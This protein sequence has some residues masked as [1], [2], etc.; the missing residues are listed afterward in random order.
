MS[1]LLESL[2]FD[3]GF[4]TL[5]AGSNQE[6]LNSEGKFGIP[7]YGG[8]AA[9]LH[10]Y[11]YRVRMRMQRE[12]L[13]DK[14]EAK[15]N[16]PLGLRLVEGLRGQ[17]LRIAQSLD[18]KVLSA[19]DGPE[20]LLQL[21]EQVLKP[22]KA[23]EAR[24]LYAAGSRDGGLL[25]RQMSEPMSS[26]V[27]RRKAWW[28]A[29]RQLDSTMQVS[30]GILA[31]QML[32]NAGVSEDQRLM[33][34]TVL[35]NDLDVEKVSSELLNQH[36]RIHEREKHRGKGYGGS[37]G[38]QHHRQPWKKPFHKGHR[39]YHAEDDQDWDA[40]SQSL[41]GF[42]ADIEAEEDFDESYVALEDYDTPDVFLAEQVAMFL[43]D[44]LDF[45]NEEAC[46][47]A[48][49]SIQLDYEAFF[50]RNQA[51]GKGHGGFAGP[52]HFEVSGQLSMQEKKAR[53][54]QLK[55]RTECRKCGQK[56]H[57]SGDPRC[58]KSTGSKSD[59]KGKK[60]ATSSTTST[61]ASGKSFKKGGVPK[62]RVVYFAM[63]HDAGNGGEFVSN[64]AV[65]D[66]S[67][68]GTLP[69]TESSS[70]STAQMLLQQ[71]YTA[72]QVLEFLLNAPQERRSL[73][74]VHEFETL[75][76]N[77]QPRGVPQSF[78]PQSLGEEPDR[79]GCLELVTQALGTL[80]EMEIDE[81][82]VVGEATGAARDP[83]PVLSLA[84]PSSVSTNVTSAPETP[85]TP[86]QMACEHQNITRRGSNSYFLL[87]TCLQC[88]KVLKRERREGSTS[89]P[90]TTASS[91]GAAKTKGGNAECPHNRV[92]WRGSNGVKWR[93][94]CLDCG[95]ITQGSHSTT[96]SQTTPSAQFLAGAH[97]PDAEGDM[98]F[99]VRDLQELMRSSQMVAMMKAQ[100]CH[101]V[102]SLE[103]VHQIIDAVGVNLARTRE[104]LPGSLPTS[105]PATS[106]PTSP[107]RPATPA[108]AADP[109]HVAGQ[110]TVTF[111]KYK[112]TPYWN[113]WQDTQYVNW[114]LAEAND[115][116]CKGMK[117]LVAYFKQKK[118]AGS[119]HEGYMAAYEEETNPVETEAKEQWLLAVLD[120][121]CNR[122]CHGDRWMQRYLKA[123]DGVE[124]DYPL[125]EE[126]SVFK[127]INGKVHTQGIRRLEVGF[128]LEGSD[129]IAVGSIDSMELQSSDAPLLLSIRDQ[130]RLELQMELNPDGQDHVYSRKLGG[131]L[132]IEHVN[133][134]LGL[135][136]LP[137]H[138]AMLSSSLAEEEDSE[139]SL[140]EASTETSHVVG[141]LHA[142]E[143][144]LQERYLNVDET[145]TKVLSRAQKKQLKQDI[146]EV[147]KQDVSMWSTLQGKKHRTALP[148]G[149]G[150]F[151][152]EIFAG[153]AM[154]TT[155]AV[156]MGLEAAA[157]VDLELDGSDLLK[158][159]VRARLE[160]EIDAVDPYVLTFSPVCGPWGPWSHLNMSKSEKTKEKIL[161]ARDDWYPTLQWI[162]KIVKK[163]LKRG[164]K[165]LVE[166]P[167]TSELWNTP[168]FRRLLQEEH[169]DAETLE[170]LELI[171]CDQCMF[172]LV[173]R[174]NQLPHLKPTGILTAS[175]NLK[176]NLEVRCNQLHPHQV[177]EGGNRTRLAQ[178]WPE[179]FCQA[180]LDG[181]VEELECRQL[182]AAFHVEDDAE[183]EVEEGSIGVLDMIQDARDMVPG[184]DLLP[185]RLDE[186]EIRR[187]EGLEEQPL[188]EGQEM[189]LEQERRQ[190]WLKIPRATRLA[191]RRL[192]NMTGHSTTSSMVQLLRTAH[193]TPAVIEACRHFACETC[194]K[195]QSVQ[196]PNTTKMPSRTTFNHEI[197]IDCL[198]VKDSLGNRHSVLSA[199]CVGT[200]F[201]QCWWVA[202]GGVPKSSI[203]A[204]AL[205]QGWFAPY[206]PP[207]VVTCDKGVHNQGKL[208]D[209]LRTHGIRLRYTGI[210]APFQLG[211]G[212]RQ[213]S[214]FKDLVATAIE[215]RQ[216]VG[217][218]EMKCL[219][220]E[221]CV[222]KNMKLNHNGFTPYQWVLGKLPLDET[223]L[224]SE[225]AQGRFLAVQEEVMEPED[226]FGFRLQVR[227]AAKV[228]FAKVDSSRRVRSALLRKSVPQRG[229]YVPGDLVCFHRLGRWHGPARVI[230]R[231]GRSTIWLVHGGV[232]VVTAESS[233]IGQPPMPRS[234]QNRSWS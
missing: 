110:K 99:D 84:A 225:E 179:K 26:Y 103:Q 192:H 76:Q 159:S 41:T 119:S 232:P 167:W 72:D 127:G 80:Q 106:A 38:Y 32:L 141:E 163:R 182:R 129:G 43:D 56:G 134:L 128:M 176:R 50:V 228:A 22:K 162:A 16:G 216:I 94:T 3:P 10:E 121:G 183:Q 9:G 233:L 114:C 118:L 215:E 125:R 227:Q 20:K 81:F 107:L 230:G 8:D 108:P 37:G 157:P 152:M 158:S 75:Q 6:D 61:A 117:E 207:E 213:G 63:H 68:H 77:A 164:R 52:R 82:E 21:F 64:M 67:S 89:T 195:K 219:I 83:L 55:L 168:S 15:K 49:E 201:H 48:A 104:S 113:A 178:Q 222:V 130:R 177:L 202:A 109:L 160:A 218:Y 181:F 98:V 70:A 133:G 144:L 79:S 139:V 2:R 146:Y 91:S 102:L 126:D 148:R 40:H 204:E 86:E 165:V 85:E 185:A 31:E 142:E 73:P 145:P 174:Q 25:S 46:A 30:E 28:Q 173:D 170:M 156:S 143:P 122:T 210:E 120:S 188:C 66:E 18:P 13:M 189:E 171:R 78:H 196:R 112:G 187:Q 24:E 59:G 14:T 124:H 226:E 101:G 135:H 186:G 200:L 71:G 197:A 150:V 191:L 231:E 132:K 92:S 153:C 57:W 194:R 193:A 234:M 53:L 175:E 42:T 12:A 62:Q 169:F 93:N 19:D 11:A 115:R 27:L 4:A 205:L 136:L 149:C 33:I 88:K 211:R 147:E 140:E 184:K 23:Q 7:R 223:S 90:S 217:V 96:S 69:S 166:N 212:E 111:G 180:I 105:R 58:P 44:G 203:C 34:R 172:G 137:S 199:V 221:M 87:E 206:G 123:I 45:E 154:L 208:K 36:P 97:Q 131:Y 47:L 100:D 161:N 1:A 214:L 220:A 65:R 229:P 151:L 60:S 209:L 35:G 116:S 39:S 5:T 74:P 138:V 54:Q 155:M 17:A 29:L 51:K 198:E 190:K 95:R 224:T